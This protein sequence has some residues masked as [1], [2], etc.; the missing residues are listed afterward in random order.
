MKFKVT[1]WPD[2]EVGL[3]RCGSLTLWLTPEALAGWQALRRTTRGGQPRYSD[4]AIE[5]V[6]TL[7][8]VFG[9]RLRQSEGLMTSLLDVMGLVLPVPD[10]TTLSRRA[11]TWE[12]SAERQRLPDDSPL[13]VLVDSTG[14][15]VYGAGQWLEDKHGARTR[16][17]WRKLHLALDADSGEIFAHCLTDQDTD[18]PSQVGPLLDRIDAEIDQFT[19]DGAYD[20]DPTYRS[21]LKRSAAA[22]I[23]IPPRITAVESDDTGGS[24]QRDDHI[25][26]IA[27]DGR[28]KWQT[29]TGYGRRALIETAIGRY[30]GLI[31]RRL[32]AR[33]FPAQR[34]E[35]AIGCAVLN[36]M[37]ACARPQSV[38]S[39]A[40]EV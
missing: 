32:R 4:L 8:C 40:S 6:L 30:R 12:P 14:L 33:S 25:R 23:V 37:T 1:N 22:R 39:L 28:L 3:R 5:T 19:A 35:V 20:G 2:Y 24:G 29:A 31:G 16:R 10:H 26:A 34:T 7:G 21:V 38:R 18:D 11:R 9:L 13:H 17:I 15:K 27:N 36:R